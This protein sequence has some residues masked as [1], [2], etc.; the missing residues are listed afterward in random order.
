MKRIFFLSIIFLFSLSEIKSGTACP[1]CIAACAGNVFLC[2]ACVLLL[3]PGTGCFSSDTI[4][5]KKKNGQLEEVSIHELKKNDLI[6]SNDENKLTTVIRNTKIEGIFN[7]V[8]LILD[9]G[10]ELTI[11]DEHGVIV[12]DNESNKKIVKA[13]NLKVGQKLITLDGPQ[14]IKTINNLKVKDKYILETKEG[15]V[16]ANNI[17]VSTI[18]AEMIDEKINA[19]DLIESWKKEHEKLYNAL[20]NN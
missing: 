1:A 12:V 3:C 19:D 17:Y 5:Y 14:E 15:T 20:I 9:S 11:T 7:Y 8:Q 18:C 2:A 16:V 6:L 4:C 13:N 10:K